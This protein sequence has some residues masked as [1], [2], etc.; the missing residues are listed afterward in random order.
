V[1][2]ALS[3]DPQRILCQGAKYSSMH[4][5]TYIYIYIYIYIGT[6]CVVFRIGEVGTVGKLSTLE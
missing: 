5:Y 6:D 4:V 3:L 1:A 2:P